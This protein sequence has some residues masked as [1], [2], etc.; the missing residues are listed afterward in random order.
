M[1]RPLLVQVFSL[2]GQD[3]P[4]GHPTFA[5]CDPSNLSPLM[6]KPPDL[7]SFLPSYYPPPR[8]TTSDAFARNFWL[9]ASYKKGKKENY[10]RRHRL[11]ILF[12]LNGDSTDQLRNS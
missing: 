12:F 11:N 5:I 7:L 3:A 4:T 8:P 2:L 6:G 9:P 10:A 1:F